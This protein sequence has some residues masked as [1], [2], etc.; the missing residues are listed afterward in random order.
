M[1]ENRDILKEV[2]KKYRF[3][4]P[5]TAQ[6][7]KRIVINRKRSLKKILKIKGFT[8]IFVAA[9][10]TIYMNI[11]KIGLTISLTKCLIAVY[12]LAAAVIIALSTGGVILVKNVILEQDQAGSF[13]E[14]NLEADNN[15]EK[16][17][18]NLPGSAN[19][20][21]I[22]ALKFKLVVLPFTFDEKTSDANDIVQ[23][24][25][26]AE[27]E[28]LKGSNKIKRIL[29]SDEDVNVSNALMG[30]VTMLDNKY[31]V[32]V[33]LLNRKSSR[34]LSMESE[35]AKNREG[36]ERACKELARKIAE[37]I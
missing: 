8:S 11:K 16:E 21:R 25:I 36:L 5:L 37:K 27:L 19:N 1:K 28:R 17:D 24:T 32:T 2:L 34:I 12:S 10:V 13:N 6:S 26:F 30:S 3:E 23:N 4:E 20:S 35:T 9:A 29:S 15:I 7:R 33:R 31:R 22:D 14:H 18:M